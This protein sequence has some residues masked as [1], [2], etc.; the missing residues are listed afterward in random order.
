MFGLLEFQLATLEPLG[1]VEAAVVLDI[2]A[3]PEQLASRAAA[4]RQKRA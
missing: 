2:A 1:R 4:W 3:T